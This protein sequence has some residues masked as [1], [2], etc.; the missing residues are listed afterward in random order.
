MMQ[1]QKYLK[2]HG[3]EKLKS[4]FSIVVTDY[5]DFVVLNYNQITSPRFNPI[6]DECRAL[7]LEKGTWKV[8]CRSFDRFYNWQESVSD[9]SNLTL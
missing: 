4:E 5:P 3:L 8:L 9:T 2:E 1:V 6:V 7:I